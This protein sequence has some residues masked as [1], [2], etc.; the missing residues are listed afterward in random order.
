MTEPYIQPFDVHIGEVDAWGRLRTRTL[1]SYMEQAVTDMSVAVGL[2]HKWYEAQGAAWAMRQ[3]QVR[4][5]APVAYREPLLVA[6]WV[7]SSQRVRLTT[8]Y[9]V[10]KQD[11]TP[12]ALG[13]SEW[14]YIDRASRRPRTLDPEITAQWPHGASS[15]LWPEQP[16]PP[17][18]PAPDLAHE[19]H[20]MTRTVYC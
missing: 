13:R 11:G 14:I 5:F 4:R 8:D 20:M 1:L 7:S 17:T 10:R 3:T 16:T 12:V 19:P 9:E 15:A 2:D 6:V 18:L